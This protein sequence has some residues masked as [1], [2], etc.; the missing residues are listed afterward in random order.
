M[1]TAHAGSAGMRLTVAALAGAALAIALGTYGKV[2]DPTGESL[3]TL[4]FSSTINL[5]AWFATIAVSF[6]LFQVLSA[7]RIYGRLSVP[8]TMPAWLPTAHRVSGTLAILFSLP[9][10]FHCLWSLGFQDL[11]ARRLVHS[12]AGCFF[13]GALFSKLIILRSRSLPGW[14]LPLAGGTL[15][16]V[17]VV[18]WLTSAFW[19]FTTFGF[20]SV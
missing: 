11:D 18:V 13:Y 1:E 12:L 15:F 5:K 9:V 19:F 20:P 2:H 7:L 14:A 4:F 3:F 6:G 16:T 17:L 8:R 10:A